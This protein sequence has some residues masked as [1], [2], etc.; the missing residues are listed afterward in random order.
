[1]S[2]TEMK[3]EKGKAFLS[4]PFPHVGL[5]DCGLE[6][7]SNLRVGVQVP[8]GAPINLQTYFPNLSYFPHA[9]P[10]FDRFCAI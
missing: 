3:R 6:R 10:L 2:R 5:S 7:T 9:L 4:R 8:P 1:M